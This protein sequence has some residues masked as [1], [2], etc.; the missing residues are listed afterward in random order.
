MVIVDGDDGGDDGGADAGNDGG[1]GD[2]DADGGDDG[3]DAKVRVLAGVEFTRRGVARP[4]NN[5]GRLCR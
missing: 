2:E 5:G 4:T 1:D 3:D